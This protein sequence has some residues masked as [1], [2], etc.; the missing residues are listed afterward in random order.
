MPPRYWTILAVF[1]LLALCIA[2]GCLAPQPSMNAPRTMVEEYVLAYNRDDAAT[3]YRMLV[4]FDSPQQHPRYATAEELGQIIHEKR[5][6]EGIR[7]ADYRILEEYIVEQ[8]AVI[9]VDVTWERD[10]EVLEESY[11]AGFL[12][13]DGAWRLVDLI[14]PPAF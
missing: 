14:L 7:I 9:T 6:I 8:Y 12:Y 1:L 2:P 10:G 13:L 5:V 4:A 11:D 3:I